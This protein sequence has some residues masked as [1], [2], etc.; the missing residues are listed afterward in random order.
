MSFVGA[1]TGIIAPTSMVFAFGILFLI[2]IT[3][4]LSIKTSKTQ[5]DIKNLLQRIALLENELRS[6]IGE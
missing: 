4:Q 1:V 3:L 6:K 5:D 2:L